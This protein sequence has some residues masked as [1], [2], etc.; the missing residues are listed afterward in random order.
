MV[1]SWYAI[2]IWISLAIVIAVPIIEYNRRKK[3]LRN[4][5]D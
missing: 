2:M 1:V 3:Y 5:N 4:R